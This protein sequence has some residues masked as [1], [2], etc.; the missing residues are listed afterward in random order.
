MKILLFL[1]ND[2]HSATAL[3]LLSD[4]LKNHETKIILSK[5]VG[6]TDSLPAELLAMKKVEQNGV[7]EFYQDKKTTTYANVNSEEALRDFKK[8]APD[9]ILSIRFGQIFKS[10][11][12]NIPRF[13]VLNLHSGKLPDYRGVMA[14]FW[15]ILNGEKKLG[16]TL[17]YIL[18]GTIDTGDVVGFAESEINW[19]KSLV[20]N[21]NR[22]YHNSCGLI[23]EALKKIETGERLE[24]LK[25]V[26]AGNYFTYPKE[27]DVAEFLEKMELVKEEDLKIAQG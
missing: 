12:I 25:Q 17:H 24:K 26:G 2:I 19:D 23:A 5:Q 1:N 7:D 20:W 16:A 18:D 8:F 27:N 14:S 4:A 6:K 15:G 13:G 9:L 3:T 22:I 10:G 21:I 11:L